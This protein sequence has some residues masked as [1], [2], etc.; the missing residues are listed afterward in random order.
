M[1]KLISSL[2]LSAH[3][4]LHC[5]CQRLNLQVLAY[6]WQRNQHELL[7]EMIDSNIHAILIKTAALGATNMPVPFIHRC[8]AGLYPKEHLGKTIAEMRPV[9]HKL[10]SRLSAQRCRDAIFMLGRQVRNQCVR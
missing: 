7:N 4:R 8:L 10:V 2:E 9:L 1:C 6:L 3:I 5:R